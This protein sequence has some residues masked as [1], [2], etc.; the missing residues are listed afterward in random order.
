[1]TWNIGDGFDFWNS[2]GD[3]VLGTGPGTWDSNSGLGLGAAVNTRFGIGQSLSCNYAGI[4]TKTVS[5]NDP[6]HHF[7]FAVKRPSG[8]TNDCFFAIGLLD[9]NNVQC[10]ISFHGD[11]SIR[12]YSGT[13]TAAAGGTGNVP[14]GT[15][16][17]SFA[18]FPAS[19]WT[20]IEIEINISNTAGYM[21]IRLN[22]NTINDFTS[23]TNLNTRNGSANNYANKIQI[24]DQGA[25]YHVGAIYTYIDDFMWFTTA[26]TAPNTWIGDVR[27]VQLM[28]ASDATVQMAKFPTA[29]ATNTACVNQAVEDG[30]TTYVN[31]LT[32]GQNDLYNVAA[33]GGTPT[34][35]VAVQTK[36]MARKTDTG[37]RQA[38]IQVKSGATTSNGSTFTL[39]SNY[40]YTTKLDIVDPATSS[41]WTAAAVNAL[42]IGPYLVA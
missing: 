8:G 6:T 33:L 30:D 25:S 40:S 22:G 4:A 5:N 36:M 9:G 29:T 1:M 2:P 12:L 35:I 11:N 15:L 28:P 23:A 38:R 16:L 37:L 21:N 24:T 41:A 20:A 17:T 14:S 34:A 18:G 13:G 42:Q 39:A 7:V 27:A 31:T 19:V 3:M 32:V 10:T 26:G